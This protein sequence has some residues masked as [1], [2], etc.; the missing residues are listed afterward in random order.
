MDMLLRIWGMLPEILAAASMI[1]AGATAITALT[2]TKT[3]DQFLSVIS[4]A[5]NFLAGNFGHNT[6]KDG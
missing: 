2:P 4:K 1:V 3:D 5:L 6:N